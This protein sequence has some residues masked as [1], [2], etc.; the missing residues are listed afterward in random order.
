MKLSFHEITERA[1]ETMRRLFPPL[2]S[3]NRYLAWLL[4]FLRDFVNISEKIYT[5][6][7]DSAREASARTHTAS[8]SVDTIY[9]SILTVMGD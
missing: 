3:K 5:K 4:T 7:I 9:A 2:L 6:L 8:F 1:F